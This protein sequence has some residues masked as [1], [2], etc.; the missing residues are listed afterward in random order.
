MGGGGMGGRGMVG[1]PGAGVGTAMQF[2]V[3]AQ[4]ARQMQQAYLLEQ[5]HASQNSQRMCHQQMSQQAVRE[6]PSTPQSR[7]ALREK[8]RQEKAARREAYLAKRQPKRTA[9]PA[10][11]SSRPSGNF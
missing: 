10:L 8:Y 1:G 6:T 4:Q 11:A 7:T 3:M 5:Q 9:A 2:M